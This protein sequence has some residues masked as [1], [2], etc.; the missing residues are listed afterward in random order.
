MTTQTKARVLA[1]HARDFGP[2]DIAVLCKCSVRDV[3]LL[4][5]GK[6]ALSPIEAAKRELLRNVPRD[7][8]GTYD[9][10]RKCVLANFG[11]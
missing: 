10:Y 5:A 8:P 3:K 11:A 4:T 1:Y 7:W 6:E 2:H 9:E